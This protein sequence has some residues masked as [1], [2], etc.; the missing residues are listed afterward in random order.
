MA[1]PLHLNLYVSLFKHFVTIFVIFWTIFVIS[2]QVGAGEPEIQFSKEKTH[3]IL[4]QGM[5]EIWLRNNVGLVYNS[6]RKK[7]I[8]KER[9]LIVSPNVVDFDEDGESEV[10]VLP[11]LN[12]I[13]M[14]FKKM[15]SM[16]KE[17]QE[18]K[19]QLFVYIATHGLQGSLHLQYGSFKE[20][21]HYPY[22]CSWIKNNIPAKTEIILMIDACYSGSFDKV[23]NFDTEFFFSSSQCDR[24]AWAGYFCNGKQIDSGDCWDEKTFYGAFTYFFFSA[25]N[26]HY[27]NLV[28]LSDDDPMK[29]YEGNKINLD[30]NHD[31]RISLNE[32]FEFCK[33]KPLLGK[34][35][36]HAKDWP[37]DYDKEGNEF[38]CPSYPQFIRW[39]YPEPLRELIEPKE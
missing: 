29:E 27:P 14:A 1:Y 26:A 4:I 24:A 6:L 2:E 35:R 34:C 30:M 17:N 3:A 37:H 25:F 9:I 33:D 15:G 23:V 38:L 19:K 10:Y 21:I 22:L 5:D 11:T 7:E 16:I 20:W 12:T 28:K 8:S 36:Y 32:A 13:E 18:E 31:G 39:E